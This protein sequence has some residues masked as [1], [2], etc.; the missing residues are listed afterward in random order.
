MTAKEAERQIEAVRDRVKMETECKA[1]MRER[2]RERE[3]AIFRRL[4]CESECFLYNWV[5]RAP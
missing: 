4:M 2:E 5:R 1:G 3:V